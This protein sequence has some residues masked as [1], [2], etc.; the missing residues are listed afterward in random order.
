MIDTRQKQT[1]GRSSRILNAKEYAAVMRGRVRIGGSLFVGHALSRGDDTSWRLGLIVPKRFEP[2]AVR[3]NALKRVWR[4]S[5]RRE[6]QTLLALNCG[7]DLVIR[8]VSKPAP[9]ALLALKR[10]ASSEAAQLFKRLP[11]SIR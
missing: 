7:H 6:C 11:K 4:D 10:A 9:G 8:L 2:S 1:F 3:R 5:F